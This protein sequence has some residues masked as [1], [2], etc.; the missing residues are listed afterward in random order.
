MIYAA[1]LLL[2]SR[3]IVM[4]PLNAVCPWINTIRCME[5]TERTLNSTGSGMAWGICLQVVLKFALVTL[6]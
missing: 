4:V 1:H 2:T 6:G 5:S 3:F